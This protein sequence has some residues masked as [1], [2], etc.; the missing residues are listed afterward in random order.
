MLDSFIITASR[1]NSN[2]SSN[3][4]EGDGIYLTNNASPNLRNLNFSGSR[5]YREGGG[6]SATAGSRPTLTDVTFMRNRADSDGGS[7]FLSNNTLVGT[8]LTFHGNVA[9]VGLDCVKSNAILTRTVFENN[10]AN[11]AAA[12]G[13]RLCLE[14]FLLGPEHSH[15]RRCDLHR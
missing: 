8:D 2:A 14:R 3:Y 6:L 10:T 9:G 4:G 7:I 1:A 11:G 5:I 13:S 15:A 12:G